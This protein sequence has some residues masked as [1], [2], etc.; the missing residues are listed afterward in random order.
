MFFDIFSGYEIY[1]TIRNHNLIGF[2]IDF[3]PD[4]IPSQ[5]S[6]ILE[7]GMDEI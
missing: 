4:E 2:W 5:N 3:I 6:N 1:F 7:K